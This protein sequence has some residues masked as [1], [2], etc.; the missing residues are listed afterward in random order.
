MVETGTH[1][2]LQKDF[3][4]IVGHHQQVLLMMRILETDN[5]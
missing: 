1:L 4:E 2:V 5:N 3:A